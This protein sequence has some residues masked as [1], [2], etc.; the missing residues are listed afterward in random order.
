V[1]SEERGD[2]HLAE[3]GRLNGPLGSV[4]LRELL[5][6]RLA[7]PASYKQQNSLSNMEGE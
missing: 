6:N 5:V 2:L 7:L 3:E 1:I 4:E